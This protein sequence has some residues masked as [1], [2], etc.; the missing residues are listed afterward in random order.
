[1]TL[2]MLGLKLNHVS[3]RGPWALVDT[4][5]PISI[6]LFI[7]LNLCLNSTSVG[8]FTSILDNSS[9]TVLADDQ[10]SV[11]ALGHRDTEH[12][13]KR[14]PSFLSGYKRFRFIC[15]KIKRAIFWFKESTTL[16][17]KYTTSRNPVACNWNT[18][19]VVCWQ[20]DIVTITR[21]IWGNFKAASI[22]SNSYTFVK[23]MKWTNF[24]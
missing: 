4:H 7:D 23:L 8:R 10:T 6:L 13:L 14:L 24:I 12:W 21:D 19:W 11:T 22:R 15:G 2:S 17:T 3:K 1:M 16:V 5:L 9:D 20:P 18:L